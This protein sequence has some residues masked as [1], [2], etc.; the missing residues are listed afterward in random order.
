MA[1]I[2]RLSTVG[3]FS[4]NGP[5]EGWAAGMLLGNGKGGNCRAGLLTLLTKKQSKYASN[6]YSN[7]TLYKSSINRVNDSKTRRLPC[8]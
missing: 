5:T 2:R 8:C 7:E 1:A 3:I 6:L 4:F